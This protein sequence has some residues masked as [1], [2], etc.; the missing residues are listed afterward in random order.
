MTIKE[1]IKENRKKFHIG[2]EIW[3]D[4]EQRK[5]VMLSDT[6]MTVGQKYITTEK[7]YTIELDTLRWIEKG[8]GYQ[9][10]YHFSK[11]DLLESLELQ[12]NIRIIYNQL[13]RDLNDPQITLQQSRDIR[14]I[15]DE[16]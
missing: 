9:G 16:K 5:N 3:F 14:A 11:R 4:D 10:E 8:Y 6:V 1:R 15:L 7:G 2:Q 13:L 12:K